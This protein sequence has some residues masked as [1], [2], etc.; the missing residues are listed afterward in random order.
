MIAS[1]EAVT[2]MFIRDE[3]PQHIERHLI[4][5]A[6]VEDITTCESTLDGRSFGSDAAAHIGSDSY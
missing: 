2:E 5:S 1:D 3:C 6:F 4:D